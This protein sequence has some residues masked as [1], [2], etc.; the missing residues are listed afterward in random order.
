MVLGSTSK[1]IDTFLKVVLGSADKN[2][3]TGI[4]PT[5]YS[6]NISKRVVIRKK[7]ADVLGVLNLSNNESFVYDL[8]DLKKKISKMNNNDIK[9]L[10]YY[11]YN[12]QSKRSLWENTQYRFEL[13]GISVLYFIRFLS[14]LL[15]SIHYSEI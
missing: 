10:K 8:I 15:V 6:N 4:R 2:C 12:L 11:D 14:R 13:I 3:Q 5:G 9:S 1:E 7:W